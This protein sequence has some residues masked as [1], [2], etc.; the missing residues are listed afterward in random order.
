[1]P[2]DGGDARDEEVEPEL[3]LEAVAAEHGAADEF[4]VAGQGDV[5]G[6]RFLRGEG[7]VEGHAA[8]VNVSVVVF[9]VKVGGVRN[10]GVE[11]VV[12]HDDAAGAGDWRRLECLVF[13]VEG[14][15]KDGVGWV[16]AVPAIRVDD[17]LQQ[18]ISTVHEVLHSH[19]VDRTLSRDWKL[20]LP[21]TL[22]FSLVPGCTPYFHP[23][24]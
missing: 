12:E 3:L 24:P 9:V 20:T 18:R 16:E 21:F 17:D 7:T 13:D 11:R 4:L 19:V 8:G 22:Y 1:L 10:G 6:G 14:G 15:D 23:T 5:L 2:G